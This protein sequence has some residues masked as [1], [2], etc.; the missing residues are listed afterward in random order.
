MGDKTISVNCVK[1]SRKSDVDADPVV[2]N[3]DLFLSRCGRPASFR[4]LL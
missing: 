3:D 2:V 1:V 4:L